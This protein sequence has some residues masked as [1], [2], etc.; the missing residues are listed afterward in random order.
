[1]VFFLLKKKIPFAIY[2]K[3]NTANKTKDK[4]AGKTSSFLPHDPQFFPPPIDCEARLRHQNLSYKQ[5]AVE[6]TKNKLMIKIHVP[7]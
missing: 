2:K 6:L 4:M 1:L 5:D 7:L 3:K